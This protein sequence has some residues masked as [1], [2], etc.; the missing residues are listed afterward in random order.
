[1]NLCQSNYIRDKGYAMGSHVG[2]ITSPITGKA[3]PITEVGYHF[4]HT[5]EN[6][7]RWAAWWRGACWE[8]FFSFCCTCLV[9]LVL[10]TLISYICFYDAARPAAARV[11]RSTSDLAFVWGRGAAAGRAHRPGRQVAVPDHGHRDPL[12]DRV[13]RPRRH[14]PHLDRHRQGRLAAREQAVERRPAVLSRSC[15]ARSLLACGIL[16]LEK[17]TGST[18][19][20]ADAVSS[21]PRR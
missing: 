2:R 13:R 15:G 3:E 4:P 5:P 12:H 20:R 18:C 9:C 21:S 6:L 11:R 17:Y 7:R 19:R 1:M 16:L 8:H 14:Q 10:L